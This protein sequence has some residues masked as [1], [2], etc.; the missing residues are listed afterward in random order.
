MSKLILLILSVVL[1][2][3]SATGYYILNEKITDGEKKF[4]AGHKQYL[5]G[6]KKLKA[7]KAQLAAGKRKLSAAKGVFGIINNTPLKNVVTKSSLG[8]NVLTHA[9]TKIKSGD[10]QV[11][12]GEK[13]IKAGEAQLKAG[14]IQLAQGTKKLNFARKIRFYSGISALCFALLSLIFLISW[15][16]SRKRLT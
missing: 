1:A 7:G 4:M 10:Q 15:I 6:E 3:F 11:A 14:K 9:E 13:Q 5:S 12:S 8:T 2:I 16:V